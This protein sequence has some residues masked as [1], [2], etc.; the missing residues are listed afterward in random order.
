MFDF[1]KEADLTF[2]V[3]QMK[4]W[5]ER[6]KSWAKFRSEVEGGKRTKL[7]T[8]LGLGKGRKL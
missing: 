8:R 7:A 2:L 1:S 6:E 4:D 5:D 3:G